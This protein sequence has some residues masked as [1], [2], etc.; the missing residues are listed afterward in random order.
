MIKTT[1]TYKIGNSLELL[2]ELPENYIDC[3]ITS[4]PYWGM[5]NNNHP[6]QVG[7]EPTPTE[8]LK[9]LIGIFDIAKRKL[10]QNGNCFIVIDDTYI[11]N[12]GCGRDASWWSTK[13]DYEGKGW[14]EINTA[15]KPNQMKKC[16][17]PTKSL[18][19]IPERLAIEMVNNGWILRNKIIWRKPKFMYEI[20]A[21]DRLNKS[22]EN[23]FHFVK[24]NKYY[25]NRSILGSHIEDIWSINPTSYDGHTSSFP[26]ELV[27]KLILIGCIENGI[28]L[29]MFLGSGS[30]LKACLETNRN[31]IGFEINPEY[32]SIIRKR[33]I[34]DTLKISSK[35]TN[36]IDV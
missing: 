4:P 9:K 29:D 15:I 12:W 30:T 32:E 23:I 17:I 36:L 6:C 25:Y 34:L 7:L 24:N 35:I 28:V 3:I 1:Q 27:K 11:S 8:Y 10:K 14:G 5:R 19:L 18:S 2:T 31:G 26:L 13:S 33:L 20:N 16:G 21:K 22:Y